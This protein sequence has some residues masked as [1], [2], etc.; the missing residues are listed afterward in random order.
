M[1][2][3]FLKSN[4]DYAHGQYREVCRAWD[5]IIGAVCAFDDIELS[6]EDLGR[7]LYVNDPEDE[8]LNIFLR[9][10][11]KFRSA[12]PLYPK[13][14]LEE[15]KKPYLLGY[16]KTIMA[17]SNLSRFATVGVP[18]EEWQFRL[19]R[20]LGKW[21]GYSFVEDNVLNKYLD[22]NAYVELTDNQSEIIELTTKLCELMNQ[23][24][25]PMSYIDY[26]NDEQT[27]IVQ[28]NRLINDVLKNR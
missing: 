28:E 5:E 23:G 6:K 8:M 7:L 10:F 3:I 25:N 12:N 27:Y 20:P 19:E 16:A 1:K 18:F 14:S 26:S 17:V 2:R 15:I 11:Y 13:Y 24:S 9:P 22:K 21:G 4:R